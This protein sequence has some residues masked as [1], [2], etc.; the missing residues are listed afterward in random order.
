MTIIRKP[1][2]TLNIVPAQTEVGLAEIKM[3]FV[4]QM[5]SSGSATS[6]ELVQNILNDNSENT[7]FGANSMLARMIRAARRIN[8]VTRIDAIGLDD[9][10]SGVDATGSVVFTGTASAAGTLYITVGSHQYNRYEITVAS[11]DTAEDIGDKL[12]T[13]ITNDVNAFVGATNDTGDVTLTAINAGTEGNFIGLKVDGSVTGIST[14]LTAFSSGATNPVLTSLFDVI[15]DERYQIIVW[16]GSYDISVVGNFLLD[17]FNVTNNILD[18]RAFLTK[19]DTHSNLLTY[20]NGLNNQCLCVMTNKLENRDAFKGGSILE[21]PAIISSYTAAVSALRLTENSNLT[22]YLTTTAALDQFGGPALASLPYFNTPIRFLPIIPTGYGFTPVELDQIKTAGGSS[23]GNN[24]S[25]NSII[26]GELTTTYKT[27]AAGN[28]DESFKFLNYVETISAVRE[29]F[30][31]NLRNRFS[32]SR[33]TEGDVLPRRSMA[34][35]KIIRAY[36]VR[37][38]QDLASDQYALLQAGEAA[39]KYFKSQLVVTIDLLTGTANVSMDAPIVTQLRRI[40]GPIQLAF[41]VNN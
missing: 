34:N 25:R 7:Y 39:L 4:G 5:T 41:S 6:G 8:K 29:Y 40:F 31:N 11:G 23:I 21:H 27:D 16:P 12:V 36:I 3:L 10:G 18:G 32:Q 24:P 38:Y 37:L 22:Q 1:E 35:E 19:Q 26:L 20:L 2:V 28:E 15:N 33:L 9:N 30:Y 17:R 14:A 13:A